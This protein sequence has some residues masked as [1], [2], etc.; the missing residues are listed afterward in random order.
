[1]QNCCQ[2]KSYSGTKIQERLSVHYDSK[3]FL[4]ITVPNL[5]ANSDIRVIISNISGRKVFD[6]ISLAVEKHLLQ[7]CGTGGTYTA[8]IMS[9]LHGTVLIYNSGIEDILQLK[10]MEA[11]CFPYKYIFTS[12]NLDGTYYLKAL[13]YV[14]QSGRYR[15]RNRYWLFSSNFLS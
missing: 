11:Q 9:S 1:M 5:S 2:D 7:V 10:R 12:I 3:H 15:Y 4:R 8:T 13:M 14:L 6:K